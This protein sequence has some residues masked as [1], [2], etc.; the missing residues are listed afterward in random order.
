MEEEED[1]LEEN[2]PED[3]SGP[4]DTFDLEEEATKYCNPDWPSLGASLSKSYRAP[5]R[6]RL[7]SPAIGFWGALQEA[8]QLGEQLSWF[9]VISDSEWEDSSTWEPIPYKLLKEIKQATADWSHFPLHSYF[10]RGAHR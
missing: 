4:G 2:E 6:F 3:L 8:H 5:R 9:P 1:D 10:G 7:P